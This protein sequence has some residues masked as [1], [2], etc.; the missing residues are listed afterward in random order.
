MALQSKDGGTFTLL[1][2]A[3][4]L[5]GGEL[6]QQIVAVMVEA[7]ASSHEPMSPAD[8]K[9]ALPE[10]EPNTIDQ[11]LKSMANRGQVHKVGR[12]L[13]YPASLDEE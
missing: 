9:E 7:G 6:S 3:A 5:Q 10:V 4:A 11:R 2:A 1:G 12:G 13:Y 8:I